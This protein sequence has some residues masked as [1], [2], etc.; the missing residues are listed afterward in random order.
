MQSERSTT[1]LYP[2]SCGDVTFHNIYNTSCF[3]LARVMNHVVYS[4]THCYHGNAIRLCLAAAD[5]EEGGS[6]FGKSV[7]YDYSEHLSYLE[8]PRYVLTSCVKLQ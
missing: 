7:S 5:K 8:K 4:H 3:L 2:P 1:E 6:R